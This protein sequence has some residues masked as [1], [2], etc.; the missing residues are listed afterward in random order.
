M[1]YSLIPSLHF[2]HYNSG[3]ENRTK[4][5]MPRGETSNE[6]QDVPGGV[7][8]D[9][10][11]GWGEGESRFWPSIQKRQK[12]IARHSIPLLG[13]NQHLLIHLQRLTPRNTCSSGPCASDVVLETRI[14]ASQGGESNKSSCQKSQVTL[15]PPPSYVPLLERASA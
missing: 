14:P 1:G 4:L 8:E 2:S 11:A 9:V 12:A 3:W 5:Y 10:L 13:S 15:P 6:S 7:S